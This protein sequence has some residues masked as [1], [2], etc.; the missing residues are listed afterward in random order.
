MAREEIQKARLNNIYP[1]AQVPKIL[2]KKVKTSGASGRLENRG[3]QE[4]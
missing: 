3:N 1:V 2:E 4:T